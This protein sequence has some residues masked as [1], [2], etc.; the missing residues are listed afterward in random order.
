MIAIKTII[1]PPFFITLADDL[2]KLSIDFSQSSNSISSQPADPKKLS[3]ILLKLVSLFFMKLPRLYG[4]SVTIRSID[5]SATFFIATIQSSL[6]SFISDIVKF[7]L[8]MWYRWLFC[9]FPAGNPRIQFRAFEL[10]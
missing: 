6:Y 1:V 7:F 4:G 10:P 3:L 5:L 8:P 9:T 2:K